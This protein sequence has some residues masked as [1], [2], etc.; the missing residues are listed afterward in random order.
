MPLE[1]G[2]WTFIAYFR[3]F[4]SYSE[5][6]SAGVKTRSSWGLVLYAPERPLEWLAMLHRCS[7]VNVEF[8][9]QAD[10]YVVQMVRKD[11]K[12]DWF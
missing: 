6:L 12:C 9:H 3:Y 1:Y 11:F 5:N 10:L 2:V 7:S 8:N 4:N